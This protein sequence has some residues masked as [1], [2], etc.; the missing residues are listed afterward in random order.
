MVLLHV[1]ALLL[2]IYLSN[3]HEPDDCSKLG[4]FPGFGKNRDTPP[5]ATVT[6]ILYADVMQMRVVRLLALTII[7]SGIASKF[8]G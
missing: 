7:P 3:S 6:I 1:I 5:T 8:E 2:M 4:L